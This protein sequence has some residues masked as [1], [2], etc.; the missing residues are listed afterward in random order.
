[1][2][3]LTAI[4]CIFFCL[5]SITLFGGC[6]RQDNSKNAKYNIDCILNGKTLSATQT[7][8]FTNT[9]DN[10]IEQLKFNLYGN[11]F[12]KNAKY[13]PISTQYLVKAYPNGLS[14]GDMQISNTKINGTNAKFSIC[15]EDQNVLAIDLDK[16]LFPDEKVVA[17]IE[18]KLNLA[19][20]IARTGYNNSTI[21]L[22][23][24]Y[25][26]LCAFSDGKFYECVY[27]DI[28]DPFYSEC[29]DYYINFTFDK[30]YKVAS[31]GTCLTCKENETTFT[32]TY[33][34]EN[35]RSFAFV[36]SEK[37]N[38]INT[39]VL[40]VKINY[41]YYDDNSPEKSIDYAVKAIK[42]FSEKFGTFPYK[43]F[44]VVQTEF[45]QGGMEFPALVMISDDLEELAY[46]EVIVHESAHQWWQSAVG[47]NEIEYG[48]LDEGLAEYSVVLF[49]E[50]YSEY[51]FSRKNLIKSSEQTYKVFCSVYDKLYK[52]VN[53]TMIRSLKDFSSEYEYVNIA[54]IKSCIMY[55]Y[56]RS[57]IG[58][59][60]FF[61]SL[62]NYYK[63]YKF[64]NVYPD[65]LVG[66]FEKIGAD[67]NGFFHSFFDGKVII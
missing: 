14:Y 58:E 40:G 1:M 55:D 54:Y 52:N 32:N 11:A 30:K 29:A 57:T 5:F 33:K 9:S 61:D 24:F 56:L 31:S 39:T 49:Y 4:I 36:L 47:N 17:Q 62:K 20:V 63:T 16:Q 38:I 42:L 34:I 45:I 59:R 51:G 21:N 46:G 27:Y 22:A 19:N 12:R 41:Y 26:I 23:N 3:K 15:G 60:R 8:E 10:V 65:N 67:T 13:S 18:F 28:G 64:K 25:P 7:V 50:N 44:A 37:F 53:T 43:T 35:A 48:F 2:K 66:I 6:S